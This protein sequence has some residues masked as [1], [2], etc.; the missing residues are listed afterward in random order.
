[1]MAA[2]FKRNKDSVGK[3]GEG[4]ANELPVLIL[5]FGNGFISF[6]HEILMFFL[7]HENCQAGGG[8]Q[9]NY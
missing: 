1:M 6:Q 7:K 2:N 4:T 5:C 3:S 9:Q 8:Y